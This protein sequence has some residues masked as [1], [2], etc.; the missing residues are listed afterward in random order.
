VI[1]D[2]ET[3]L[4]GRRTCRRCGTPLRPLDQG[5]GQP[6]SCRCDGEMIASAEFRRPPLSPWVERSR[7]RPT[8]PSLAVSAEVA[9]GK[10]CER[11]GEANDWPRSHRRP[12][13][14][15]LESLQCRPDWAVGRR[16]GVAEKSPNYPFTGPPCP[17]PTHITS[18]HGLCQARTTN[19]SRIPMVR[20][21]LCRSRR[22]G[23]MRDKGSKESERG[24]VLS[25]PGLPPVSDHDDA[26]ECARIGLD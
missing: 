10:T 12:P 19:L 2:R 3:S 26:N 21:A 8:K 18:S 25:V 6:N 20:E 15:L 1:N 7:N 22:G 11:C 17:T 13:A 5:K 16:R 14:C 23:G 4:S 24:G 9:A